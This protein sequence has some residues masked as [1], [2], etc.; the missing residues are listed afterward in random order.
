M[1]FNAEAVMGRSDEKKCLKPP[2]VENRH[3]LISIPPSC[4]A[5]PLYKMML[6]KKIPVSIIMFHKLCR[7]SRKDAKLEKHL[8]M[9]LH[10]NILPQQPTHVGN[11]RLTEKSYIFYCIPYVMCSLS[12]EKRIYE[13]YLK[14]KGEYFFKFSSLSISAGTDVYEL[15]CIN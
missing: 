2:K 8:V 15:T 4:F 13:K 11:S 5:F 6:H 3:C 12:R 1:P 7:L 9:I 10:L 14:S